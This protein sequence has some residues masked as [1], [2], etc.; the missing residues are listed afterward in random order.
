M[1][2]VDEYRSDGSLYDGI[3]Q[4]STLESVTFPSTLK[5]IEYR[6]FKDCR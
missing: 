6:A 1:L 3:F 2:G 5:K 4:E